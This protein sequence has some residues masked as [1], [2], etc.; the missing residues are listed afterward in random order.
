MALIQNIATKEMI[1]LNT[2]H[3]FGRNQYNVNTYLPELDISQLHAIITWKGNSWYLFDQSRNGTLVNGKFVNNNAL[4]LTK[5]TKIQFGEEKTTEWEVLDCKEPN[6]YL[7][8]IVDLNKIIELTSS[9]V[10]PNEENPAVFIYPSN[11]IWKL[12]KNGKIKNLSANLK[13]SINNEDFIFIENKMLEDTMDM[14]FGMTEAY[15][16]FILSSDE[17]HIRLKL[18][19]KNQEIDLGERV[20]NYILLALARKKLLDNDA[21]YVVNDQGW[22]AID[23][24]LEELSKELNKDIDIYYLNLKIHRIR[25]LILDVKHYGSL[26]SNIIERRPREIRFSHPFFQILKEEKSIGEILSHSA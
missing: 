11:G 2:Q 24:L 23:D 20:H 12:E 25:K 3:T 13:Y 4:A 5:G 26:F 17:E 16:Q 7:Q 14:G 21:G 8:S 1:Y 18:I 22:M 19:T 9:H 10:F 15:F 6:S